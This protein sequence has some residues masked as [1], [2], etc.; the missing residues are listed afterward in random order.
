MVHLLEANSK[1]MFVAGDDD[2]AIFRYAGADVDYFIGLEGS[3][4]VLDQSY[5][6]PSLH[7]TLSQKVIQRVVD[8]RPKEFNPRDEEGFVH[9]HRHSEEV[10][11]SNGE[12][13]LL[14][15]TTRGAKQ[16]EEEVRRRGHLY[17]STMA[18]N[19]LM[20]KFWKQC[21]LWENM[22]NG[23]TLTAEQVRIC[24]QPDVIR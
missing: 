11:M 14:S 5:R 8:R 7:H 19:L 1:E 10:D 4:T 15:R 18:V 17:M 16:I 13:L 22:R 2:Q 3:V 23:S 9:W 21:G 6:I 24:I 20:V 12:W